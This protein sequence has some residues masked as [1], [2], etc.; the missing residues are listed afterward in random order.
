[1]SS[2]PLDIAGQWAKLNESIAT[3]VDYIP[4]DKLD[5]AP[6]EDLWNFRGIV[7]HVIMAR[8]NWLR[9][10]VKDGEDTP[11]VLRIAQTKDGMQRELRR[12]W[13]RLERFLSDAEKLAASYSWND[14]Q[15]PEVHKGHWVA[16][17]LLEHDVHHRAD[18]F[19]YLA[20]LGIEHPQV[21]TP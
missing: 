21:G 6:S 15:W 1:M 3:L 7:L 9:G 20:L 12:S 2:V 8:E 10:F 11:N 16:F 14:P 17:H 4:D 13:E 19:H 18:V 5:Y